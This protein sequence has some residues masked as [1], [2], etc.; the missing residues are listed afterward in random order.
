MPNQ[1]H[2][3]LSRPQNWLLVQQKCACLLFGFLL[4]L[5]G[6][7]NHGISYYQSLTE[8]WRVPEMAHLTSLMIRLTSSPPT[9]EMYLPSCWILAG[10]GMALADRV[11]WKWCLCFFP[12]L[13]L[14]ATASPFLL[15]SLVLV[16]SN[17]QPYWEEAQP[18]PQITWIGPHWTELTPP[19]NRP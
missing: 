18:S 14:C 12:T 3:S 8:A 13:C 17:Q 6:S 7:S 15:L 1:I 2:T 5:Q 11:W 19:T 16:F 4:F 9:C 10:D